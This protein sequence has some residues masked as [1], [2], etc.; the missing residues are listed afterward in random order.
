MVESNF[1]RGMTMFEGDWTVFFTRTISLT[2]LIL[3]ALSAD[4]PI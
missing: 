3:S 1:R 4:L 2:F